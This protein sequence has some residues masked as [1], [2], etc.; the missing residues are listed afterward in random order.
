MAKHN[1]VR[2]NLVQEKASRLS[3]LNAQAEA[4]LSTVRNQI[5]SL[6]KINEE[7]DKE[8]GEIDEYISSLTE[9]R[10]GLRAEADR[11]TKVA[12]NFAKLLC[13]E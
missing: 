9:T 2:V 5:T 7:I 3:F 6:G 1:Q 4:T 12:T 10:N 11:N 13:L 8:L